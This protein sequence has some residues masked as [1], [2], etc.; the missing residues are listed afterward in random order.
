MFIPADGLYHSLLSS[1]VGT[2]EVNSKNLIEYAFNKKVM[3]VSPMSLFPYL[4][5]A[6]K[7]LNELKMEANIEVIKKNLYNLTNHLQAYEDCI[8]RLGK[9]LGT[10]VNQ[11]NEASSE[12]KKIDKDVIRISDGDTQIDFDQELLDR[13]LLA[14]DE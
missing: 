3:I 11:Y 13:P 12:F 9:N 5:T 6:L 10:V 8:Q 4:Q 1:K 7:A 14:G 2:L